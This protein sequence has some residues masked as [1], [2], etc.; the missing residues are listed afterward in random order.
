MSRGFWA[1]V[2][3]SATTRFNA[4]AAERRLKRGAGAKE[5]YPRT[6]GSPS[7][8]P[9]RAPKHVR[10]PK[11]EPPARVP[12]PDPAPRTP[13][14]PTA[15]TN[16]AHPILY[17]R[18]ESR[19]SQLPPSIGLGK[20]ENGKIYRYRTED[21][22]GYNA[23]QDQTSLE[24]TEMKNRRSQTSGPY[25]IARR[26]VATVTLGMTSLVIVGLQVNVHAQDA[27]DKEP[28][29]VWERTYGIY[30]GFHGSKMT[31]DGHIITLASNVDENIHLLKLNAVGDIVWWKSFGGPEE[32]VANSVME[33]S[34]GG[35]IITGYTKSFPKPGDT[36]GAPDAYLIKTDAL[37]ELDWEMTFG[38][39][40]EDRGMFVHEL[41]DGSLRIIATSEE[42]LPNGLYLFTTNDAGTL[43][44]DRSYQGGSATMGT[45]I[46]TQDGGYML[47]SNDTR[48][49]IRIDPQ[50]DEA[51]R[52]G[53]RDDIGRITA[54]KQTSDGGFIGTTASMGPVSG[55]SL[56]RLGSDGNVAWV[57]DIIDF[58]L[59]GPHTVEETIVGGYI[60]GGVHA[61][62]RPA[63]NVLALNSLGEFEW[64]LIVNSSSNFD[65]TSI[66]S[67]IEQKEDSYFITGQEVHVIGPLH[68]PQFTFKGYMAKIEVKARNSTDPIGF[69]YE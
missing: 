19:I 45:G 38:G 37:G 21:D 13:R 20:F 26:A 24:P 15:D 17:S 5:S 63:S 42:S 11:T 10:R 44:D 53:Y 51:W 25:P 23:V 18:R 2:G 47:Y 30:E 50:L 35:F 57:I 36:S 59:G 52:R 49:F 32:D 39:P 6:E 41:T 7:Q 55:S 3:S 22:L 14:K 27:N 9:S 68:R 8:R 48:E 43:T 62:G 33:A 46:P 31:S 66:R 69:L 65:F 28:V 56:L 60:V 64:S 54:L 4:L 58:G 12:P 61:I 16:A 67:V 1:R 40:G 34:D 29:V